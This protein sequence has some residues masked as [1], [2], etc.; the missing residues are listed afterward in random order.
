MVAC[1]INIAESIE[2]DTEPSSY[3]E[4]LKRKDRKKWEKAMDEEMDSLMK[5]T[6]WRLVQKPNDKKVVGCRC[7]YK[8]KEGIPGVEQE[9]Y[10]VRLVAKGFTQGIPGI[11]LNEIYSPVV[12]H[13][14]IR[15]LLALVTHLDLIKFDQL[16]VKITFLHGYL[17][18]TIYMQQ[19][20]GFIK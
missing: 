13:C 12:K 10:K 14:S 17:E 5:N 3:K 9:R 6:T 1:A 20:E 11:D 7:I 16:D 19:P 15:L 18:E 4:V 2:E 8:K